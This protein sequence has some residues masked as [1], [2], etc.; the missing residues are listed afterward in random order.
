MAVRGVPAVQDVLERLRM[1]SE[2]DN[3]AAILI[4]KL[5]RLPTVPEAEKEVLWADWAGPALED[6]AS[7]DGAGSRGWKKRGIRRRWAS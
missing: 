5:S 1:V 4:T 2:V 3:A 6:G 7:R